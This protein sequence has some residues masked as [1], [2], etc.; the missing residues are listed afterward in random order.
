MEERKRGKSMRNNSLYE[1]M[2]LRCLAV[3]RKNRNEVIAEIESK[4]EIDLGIG[5]KYASLRRLK[6][7]RFVKEIKDP[8]NRGKVLEITQAGKD[9]LEQIE[10]F[11][12]S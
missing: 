9:E 7:A 1:A 3:N 10:N 4:V 12:R 8:T 6:E 2:A 11:W 5:A